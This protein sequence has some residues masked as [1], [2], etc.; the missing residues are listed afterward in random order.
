VLRIVLLYFIIVYNCLDEVLR[1][2]L[3]RRCVIC[4]T[5]VYNS[6]L[7]FSVTYFVVLY[8]V[9]RFVTHIIVVYYYLEYVLH[10]LLLYI[11]FS[12]CV[13]YIMV[14]YY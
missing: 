7:L 3:L 14:V 10:R 5:A 1:T 9:R 4:V 2:L 12:L 6:I 11:L 8:Y 13:T